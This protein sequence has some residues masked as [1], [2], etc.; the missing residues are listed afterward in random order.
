[1]GTT[2]T[3][4]NTDWGLCVTDKW[5]RDRVIPPESG[6]KDGFKPRRGRIGWLDWLAWLRV[7]AGQKNK[8]VG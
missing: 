3:D 7:A 1:M 4:D 5:Q 6:C 8:L 2:H